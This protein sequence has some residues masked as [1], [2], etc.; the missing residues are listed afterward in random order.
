MLEQ[1]IS[2][3]AW[4]PWHSPIV[5]VPKPDGLL[6]LCVDFRKFNE[7]FHFN[8]FPMPQVSE[9]LERVGQARFISTSDLAKAIGGFL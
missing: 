1:G 5:A 3:E 4:S 8:A 2:Q 9:L 7:I 6:R